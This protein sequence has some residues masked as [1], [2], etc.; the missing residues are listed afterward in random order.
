MQNILKGP[1]YSGK[2]QTKFQEIIVENKLGHINEISNHAKHQKM[3]L[4]E[5]KIP[6]LNETRGGDKETLKTGEVALTNLITQENLSDKVPIFNIY[7]ETEKM[8]NINQDR[9]KIKPYNN[10][11]LG[12]IN[13]MQIHMLVDTGA[14]ISLVSDKFRQKLNSA[15][16]PLEVPIYTITA[17]NEKIC[18]KGFSKL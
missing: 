10:H 9:I 8:D 17:T 12:Y 1:I 2:E 18:I 5:V 14:T 3:R 7:Q 13:K 15:I 11:V 6:N 16:I 4:N